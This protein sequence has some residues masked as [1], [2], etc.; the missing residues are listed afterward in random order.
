M[1]IRTHPSMTVLY[2]SR[3]AT[4]DDLKSFS[5]SIIR[6]LYR[7]VTDLDLI[8]CGPQYWFY[9]GADGSARDSPAGPLNLSDKFTV[10]IALPVQGRIPTAVLP[11]FKRLPAF[12]CLT[13]RHKGSWDGLAEEYRRMLQHIKANGLGMNG[14]YAESFLHIDF[15]EPGNHI[16]EI[17]IGL[18]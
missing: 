16:T 3:Q 18:T 5:G 2:H 11:F 7:Y 14:V 13:S 4:L 6:D 10:E 8:V 12:R 1:V 9:H 15:D 17:Q